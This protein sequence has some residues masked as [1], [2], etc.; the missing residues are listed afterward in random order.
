M[1]MLKKLL[2]VRSFNNIM[3]HLTIFLGGLGFPQWFDL[4]A[5]PSWDV[6]V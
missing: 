6:G 2:G 5:P 4:L 1:A 3:G